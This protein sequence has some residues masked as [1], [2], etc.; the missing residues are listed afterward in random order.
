MQ[1]Y[2]KIVSPEGEIIGVH[3]SNVI[4]NPYDEDSGNAYVEITYEEY[5]EVCE[6]IG[7]DP[8]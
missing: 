8:R 4:E 7:A 5:L 3:V 1:H 6:Q 2:Y